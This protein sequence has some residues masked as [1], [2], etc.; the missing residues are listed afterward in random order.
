MHRVAVRHSLGL[1]GALNGHQSWEILC[2]HQCRIL[3]ADIPE[4][5]DKNEA[6]KRRLQVWEVGEMHHLIGRTLGQQHT[7]RKTRMCRVGRGASKKL[8]YP[9]IQNEPRLRAQRG[10]QVDTKMHEELCGAE[11]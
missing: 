6:L 4:G 7:G 9:Q 2:C 10:E 8:R 3:L 5:F 11:P 1:E